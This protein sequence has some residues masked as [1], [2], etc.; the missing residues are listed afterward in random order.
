MDDFYKVYHGYV[1]NTL[2]DKKGL[3]GELLQKL[4]EVRKLISTISAIINIKSQL[5]AI[6]RISKPFAFG[7]L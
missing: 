6:P 5:T 2:L 7:T 4:S 3:P 1:E